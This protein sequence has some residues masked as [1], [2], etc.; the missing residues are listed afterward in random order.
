MRL[1]P[2]YTIAPAATKAIA[3]LRPWERLEFDAER[4]HGLLEATAAQLC[5]APHELGRLHEVEAAVSAD[6]PRKSRRRTTG[7]RSNVE[8]LEA[9]V[10][11]YEH[12]VCSIVAPHVAAAYDGGRVRCSEVVF[13]AMPA[14]RVVAPSSKAAGQRHRDGAYGHQPS[15]VN[16]WM[17]LAP[18]FGNNTLWLEPEGSSGDAGSGRAVLQSEHAVP[19]EGD[20]GTLHRFH[21]HKL[22]HFTRPNDT[23]ATRVSLDFRVVPGPLYDDDFAGSRSPDTGRQSFFL[24]GYYSKARLDRASGEW[25]VCRAAGGGSLLR[26]NAAKRARRSGGVA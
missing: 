15:Q 23:P 3:P 2:S 8:A 16:F 25:H 12:F 26:G 7:A 19:L 21:G 22:F 14:L 9:L 10:C 24:G 6:R 18:A 1:I 11:V 13:Q 17:P 20:F 5:C 4:W